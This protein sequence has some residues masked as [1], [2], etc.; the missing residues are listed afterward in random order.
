[1][2]RWWDSA[3]HTSAH[4]QAIEQQWLKKLVSPREVSAKQKNKKTKNKT[5]LGYVWESLT[6]FGL[7]RMCRLEHWVKFSQN[8]FPLASSNESWPVTARRG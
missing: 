7:K 5:L 8:P 1:M 6:V 4:Q 3:G 2:M